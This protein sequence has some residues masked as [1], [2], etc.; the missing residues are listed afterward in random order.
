MLVSCDSKRRVDVSGLFYWLIAISIY[1][2]QLQSKARQN[3]GKVRMPKLLFAITV[4][5]KDKSTLSRVDELNKLAGLQ[6]MGRHSS[7]GRALQPW[8]TRR[9]RVRI[10]LKSG[11]LKLFF[12]LFRNC[13]NC[14]SLRCHIFISYIFL[15]R[16]IL[17]W[18]R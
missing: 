3:I 7:T 12:G 10:P 11:N 15:C 9:P 18:S 14:D 16:K 8:L 6:C 17:K 5:Y 1:S 13:L 4:C 2:I